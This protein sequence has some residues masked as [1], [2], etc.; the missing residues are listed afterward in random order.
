MILNKKGQFSIIA[1]LFVAVVLIATVVMTYS[2]IRTSQFADQPQILSAIDVTNLA[3]K[4]VLGFTLGYYGSILQVTGNQSYANILALQYL[5]SG[6]VNIGNMNPEWGTSFN[7]TKSAF[8]LNWFSNRSYSQGNVTVRYSL[9]GLGIKGITYSASCQLGVTVMKSLSNQAKVNIIQDQNQPLVNLGL[10]NFKFYQ[11]SLTNS[12]WKQ[13]YPSGE[14]SS[15]ANGTYLI[16]V[17]SGVDPLSFLIQVQDS[18]G[19]ITVASSFNHYS[20]VLNWNSTVYS[21][22]LNAILSV[23][24]LQNGT[25]RCLGQNFQLT[26]QNKPLP[27]LPVKSIRVNETTSGMNQQVP[28]QIEDWTSNF[29]VPLGLTSNA[30]VFS[31]RNLLVFLINPNVSRVTIWWDG[32]DIAKQTPYAYT[33]RYF[34]GDKP[35]NNYLTNGILKLTFSFGSGTVT[36]LVGTVTS[37][38]SLQRINNVWSTY[39]SPEAYTISDGIVRDVVLVE[40]EWSNGVSNCP[41]FYSSTVFTLPANVTYFTFQMRITF[42][43]TNQP[44]TISDLCLASVT[45]SVS[46]TQPQTENGTQGGYPIISSKTALFYNSSTV[47][48]AHHWSQINSTTNGVGVAFPNNSNKELYAFDNATNKVGGLNVA[49]GSIQVQPVGRNSVSFKYALDT[50]WYG[51]VD[52]FNAKTQQVYSGNKAGLWVTAEYPPTYSID[53]N[54]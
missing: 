6:F 34:Q 7:V 23:E 38:T 30:S 48:S 22:S 4:Q 26:G 42:L 24:L 19:I 3:I 11:Y 17:P 33:N 9:I 8:H 37:T 2:S 25:M 28:F 49:A 12:S 29:K 47:C 50:I 20:C 10:T 43:N 36:A 14:P 15:F 40:S 21:A 35:A 54:S 41:D 45:S 13:I 27:P 5:Q 18:R 32:S 16:N 44:R 1:A 51:M 53:T 31:N 52:T 39:G 46:G